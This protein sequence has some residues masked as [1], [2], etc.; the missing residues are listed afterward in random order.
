MWSLWTLDKVI[1]ITKWKLNPKSL[2]HWIPQL[3][4]RR[5]NLLRL[6][7]YGIF[8]ILSLLVYTVVVQTVYHTTPNDKLISEICFLLF[9]WLLFTVF[10]LK[11]NYNLPLGLPA[12]H[13]DSNRLPL[14]QWWLQWSRG[15]GYLDH[16]SPVQENQQIFVM[17]WKTKGFFFSLSWSPWIY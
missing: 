1:T 2:S 13:W 4:F 14:E 17:K 11:V 10:L 5:C 7:I 6:K 12:N 8:V 3:Y 15:E 16:K 9:F